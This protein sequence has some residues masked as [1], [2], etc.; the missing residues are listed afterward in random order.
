MRVFVTGA[1]GWIGS[2]V[3]PELIGAGHQVLGLVRSPEKAAAVED[4]GAEVLLGSLED[5]DTLRQGAESSDAVI[6]LAYIHDFS[7]IDAAATVDRAAITVFGDALAGTDKPLSIASGTLGLAAVLGRPATEDDRPD[8]SFHPR[9]ATAAAALELASRGFRTS[10]VR[11]SPTVHGDGD[12]GFT[13]TLIAVAREQ[14]VSAYPGDGS[15]RWTAVHRAD[16]ASLFRLAI[17][18]APAGSVLHGVAEQAITSR[19]VATQIGQGLGLPVESV[20][21]EQATEHFGWIGRFFAVDGAAANEI[22][23]RSLGWEPTGPTLFEDFAAGHY[24]A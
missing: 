17:E 14:G 10:V 18:R 19:D 23:R 1:S 8:A 13:P 6:H 21:I 24:F 9:T 12:K 20:P 3:V 2:A 7:Q 15:N 5:L 16:A 4:A 11:L 22:T